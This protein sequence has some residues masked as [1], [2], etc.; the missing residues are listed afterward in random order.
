MLSVKPQ[1]LAGVLNQLKDQLS[2]DTMVLSIVAGASM[3][4]LSDGLSTAESRAAYP[5]CPV[6]F[7]RDDSVGSP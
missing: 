1:S 2:E 4:I 7:E 6:G 5:T 3:R